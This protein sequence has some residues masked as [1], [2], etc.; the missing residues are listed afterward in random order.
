VTGL[1]TTWPVR[2]PK[3]RRVEPA[4]TSTGSHDG[5]PGGSI[6]MWRVP[7]DGIGLVTGIRCRQSHTRSSHGPCALA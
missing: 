2:D 6:Q 7:A 3:H 4:E 1:S 5:K